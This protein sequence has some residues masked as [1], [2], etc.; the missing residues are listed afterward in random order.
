MN[1]NSDKL[2]GFEGSVKKNGLKRSEEG[3]DKWHSDIGFEEESEY[4]QML[5]TL[6]KGTKSVDIGCGSGFIEIFSPETIAVDFSEE[7]L[8]IAK[9]NGAKHLVK[10]TAEK[11][12]FKNNE[13]EISL[14]NGVL[15]HCYDQEKAISEMV[16]ISRIQILIVH[17][18]LPYGLENIRKLIG[19]IFGLK[20]QPI[21]NPLTMGEVEGMLK[22][23]GSRVLVRGVWNYIDLR[24]LWRKLPYGIVKTPSHHFIIAVKTANLE[25]KF[26]GD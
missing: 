3:Y 12:P 18:K 11:L 24:W 5:G 26:L 14:S 17:A 15:E 19:L 6:L 25:R 4:Y 7:A 8:K 20:D 23:N 22:K 10:A 16:R 9:K 2:L 21:E 13:F 1:K